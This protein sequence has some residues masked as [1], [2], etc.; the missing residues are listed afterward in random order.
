MKDRSIYCLNNISPVGLK[1][2]REGY[3][4]TDS[5]ED[6]HAILVRA[7]SMHEMQF[8]PSLRAIAR[9]GAGV[10]NIP[11]ERCAEE[12]IV[13]FN[14]P[15]ANANAVK[16]LVVAGLMLASRDIIG[17]VRWVEEHADDPDIAKTAE[18]AKKAYGGC[19]ISGKKLGVIGLGA[20]GVLVANTALSLGMEVY[21]YDP[22]ISVGSAWSLRRGVHHSEKVEELY[23]N[24]DYITIHVPATPATNH[25]INAEAIARMKDGVRLLNFARD[26]LVD[27]EALAEALEK[28]KVSAY[29]TDF[30]TPASVRMKHAVVTPHLGA[31]TEESEEKCAVM[32]VREITDYLDNGNILHSVNFPDLDAGICQSES[33]IACLHRNIPNMLGQLTA[34][35]GEENI[36][37]AH[38]INKSREKYACTVFDI[39]SRITDGALDRIKGIEGMLRVRIVK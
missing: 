6:A 20:I 28:G 9:A 39:E 2:L 4:L 33:R 29:I 38:L 3:S 22:Y 1:E 15:G 7:A 17:G 18:K 24:C 8:S 11:L 13:V 26:L 27:E 21:G 16:E 34:I 10:N 14:T 35:M 5:P 36:N 30:A 31:S 25:M 23:E 19:E 32:A 12:G 37:I